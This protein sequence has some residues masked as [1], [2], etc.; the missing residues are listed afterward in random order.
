[1]NRGYCGIGIYNVKHDVNVGGLWRHAHAFGASFVFTIGRRYRR[2]ASDTTKAYRHLPMFRYE[3]AEDFLSHRPRD[4]Q[5]VGIEIADGSIPLQK[6]YHPE[7]AI[8]LLGAEDHGIPD[9]LLDQCQSI[10][11]I[12][13]RFCL[14]VASTGAVVLY[15]RTIQKPTAHPTCLLHNL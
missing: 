3:D 10:V 12:P 5:L 8:Y 4:C 13:T 7:R 9:W 6:F 14:N 1:M 11:E 15:D 2:E